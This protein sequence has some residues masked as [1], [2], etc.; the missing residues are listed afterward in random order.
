MKHARV[1]FTDVGESLADG[2]GWQYDG[3]VEDKIKELKHEDKVMCLLAGILRRL[4]RMDT[5]QPEKDLL[6]RIFGRKPSPKPPQASDP[7]ADAMLAI[8]RRAA[9]NVEITDGDIMEL[10]VRARKALL[11]AKVRYFD[12]IN[13]MELREVRNCG[14]ATILEIR[15]WRDNHLAN[16]S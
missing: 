6:E 5:N 10:S 3:T 12:E 2:W 4:K 8:Y 16:P 1:N 7:T 11:R 15:E 9:G 14:V 13:E